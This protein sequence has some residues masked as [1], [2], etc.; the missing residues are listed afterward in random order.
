[1]DFR[2]LNDVTFGD[3]FPIPV[4]SEILDALGKSKYFSTIDSASGFLQVPVKLEDEAKT[5]FSTRD[6]HFQYTRMP[7]GMKGAPATFQRLMTTILS[8]IQGI[9]FLVYLDDVV[10]F[11]EDLRMHNDRLIEVFSR[12]RKYNM[13]LQPDKCEFLRKEVSYLGHVIGL[14]GV[15]PD[16]KRIEAAK[17]YPKRKTTRE[18]KGFLDLPAYYHRF[19]P[20]FSKIAKPLT[21]LLKKDAHMIGM[22]RRKKLSPP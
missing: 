1:V 20:N 12:M 21:E 16:E 19:I 9:K 8:G 10:V 13:K 5:A 15:R 7:F 18:F 4:V 3:S 11:G 2:K 6:G 14:T 22:T 17:D